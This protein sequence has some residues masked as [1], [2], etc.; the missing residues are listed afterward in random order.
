M[1]VGTSTLNFSLLVELALP[2]LTQTPSARNQCIVLSCVAFLL[3]CD[4]KM[5]KV[6]LL[7]PY[8]LGDGA[9]GLRNGNGAIQLLASFL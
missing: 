8:Y 1:L 6:W 5:I 2:G 3:E 9:L 7:A 4:T